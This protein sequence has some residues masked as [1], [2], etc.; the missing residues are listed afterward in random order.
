M[1]LINALEFVIKSPIKKLADL[2]FSRRR[3]SNQL[4][5]RNT[6]RLFQSWA[7]GDLNP[8]ILSNTGT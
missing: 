1:L 7:R 8:H 4:T 5:A 3:I 6:Q 2:V